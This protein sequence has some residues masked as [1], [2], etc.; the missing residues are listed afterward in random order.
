MIRCRNPVACPGTGPARRPLCY[1]AG[2]LLELLDLDPVAQA[3][4]LAYLRAVAFGL[5]AATRVFEALRCHNQGIGVMHS[6]FAIASVLGLSPTS[7]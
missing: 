6:P 4:S 5:P 7:H 1:F 3:K 2:P